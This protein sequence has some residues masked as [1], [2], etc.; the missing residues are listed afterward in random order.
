MSDN[1]FMVRPG[2]RVV[3]A[4]IINFLCA[5]VILNWFLED[6]L[7]VFVGTFLVFA[8]AL[9]QLVN[10]LLYRINPSPVG[11]T[12]QDIMGKTHNYNYNQIEYVKVKVTYR[13]LVYYDLI[14]EGKKALRIYPTYKM[15]REF[16]MR[17]PSH[18]VPFYFR[19]EKINNFNVNMFSYS[20]DRSK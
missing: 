1:L 8:Y 20:R 12:Y 13:G 9:Y 19:G 17:L 4:T 7:I 5:I 18:E 6:R 14:V 11:F 2:K 10:Y 3:I 16:L 15:A